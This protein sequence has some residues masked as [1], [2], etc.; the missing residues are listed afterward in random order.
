MGIQI[1][2]S[3]GHPKAKH[4]LIQEMQFNDYQFITRMN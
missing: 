1:K 2:S 3:F 4:W